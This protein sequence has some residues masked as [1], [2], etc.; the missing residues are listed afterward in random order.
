MFLNYAARDRIYSH[1]GYSA[2]DYLTQGLR[3]SVDELGSNAF[4]SD[5]EIEAEF[6]RTVSHDRDHDH[7]YSFERGMLNLSTT[8]NRRTPLAEQNLDLTPGSLMYTPSVRTTPSSI[9]RMFSDQQEIL[10]ELLK[11]QQQIKESYEAV[12][13]RMDEFEG[14]VNSILTSNTPSSSSPES[15]KKRRVVT[16]NLSVCAFLCVDELFSK[17]M[18]IFNVIF[19]FRKG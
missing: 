9:E 4:S 18:S 12:N 10:R 17:F 14:K 19:L 13:K 7:M 3:L 1:G 11:Q 16:N 15:C 8:P 5:S 2:G 6:E